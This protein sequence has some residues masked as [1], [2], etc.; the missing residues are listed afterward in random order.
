MP[1]HWFGISQHLDQDRWQAAVDRAYFRMKPPAREHPIKTAWT[2]ARKMERALRGL[3]R[4]RSLMR[5]RPD[6]VR[7]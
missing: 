6:P 2:Q 7:A 1:L 4:H 5:N 3:Y